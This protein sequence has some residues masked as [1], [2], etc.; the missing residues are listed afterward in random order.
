MSTFHC[1]SCDDTYQLHWRDPNGTNVCR[2]CAAR[3]AGACIW[4]DQHPQHLSEHPCSYGSE[5]PGDPCRW[6]AG[7]VPDDG[8]CRACLIVFADLPFAD[9][10]ALFA[11][12]GTFSLGGLGPARQEDQS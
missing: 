4:A 12:D 7:P 5:A 3:N 10:K 8:M 6:C 11:A 9:V 2:T 1:P